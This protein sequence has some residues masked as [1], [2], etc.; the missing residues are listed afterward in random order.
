MP[1]YD[2]RYKIWEGHRRGPLFRWLAIPKYYL[3]DF[4]NHRLFITLFILSWIQFLLRVVYVY[5]LVNTQFLKALKI[6]PEV[7][8]Q[9]NASF[10]KSMIDI[11]LFFCFAFAFLLGSG[12]VAKDLAHNALVLY[13]SKPISRWEYFLGK[14]SV[15]FGLCLTLTGGQAALLYG[16]QWVVS[17]AHSP[18]RLYFWSGYAWIFGA[19]AAYA[20]VASAVISLLI[21]AASCLTRN[22]R[23]AGSIFAIYLVGAVFVGG[24]LE[25]GLHLHNFWAISPFHSL[26]ALGLYL[27]DAARTSNPLVGY[28]AA[29][30]ALAG[31]AALAGVII[32]A[33]LDRA[34][35]HGH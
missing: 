6:Q 30:G 20:F 27:F 5:L 22:P 12:L 31:N 24:A 34:A 4:F 32:K 2:Y 26:Y 28:A 15:I 8:P 35:R 23:H 19:L 7:L 14:I 9:I 25:E 17:P 10:F 1:V 33:R 16:L 29:W 3:A 21:M 13:V 11:Q 18:W